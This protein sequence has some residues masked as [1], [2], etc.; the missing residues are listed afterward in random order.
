LAQGAGQ[1]IYDDGL[2]D[3]TI[4]TSE[5]KM[6]AVTTMLKMLGSALVGADAQQQNVLHGRAKEITITTNPPQKVVV[7]GEVIGMTPIT[8]ECIPKGLSVLAPT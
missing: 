2:L 6:Q 4:A 8:L 1:V 7:D 5:T 3:I